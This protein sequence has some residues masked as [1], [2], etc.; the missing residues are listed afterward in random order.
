[1]E[2]LTRH[3]HAID[4]G[5][6]DLVPG[7]EPLLEQ[8]LERGL[9]RVQRD[10]TCFTQHRV[11]RLGVTII[12]GPQVHHHRGLELTEQRRTDRP[13]T[14]RPMVSATRPT[15]NR[16]FRDARVYDSQGQAPRAMSNRSSQTRGALLGLAAAALFGL[17]APLAKLLLG[18]ISPVL[19]GGLLYLGAACGLW[20]H[21]LVRPSTAETP[22]SGRDVPK[23]AAIV[24]TGGLLG[25][26]IML[27]GLQ[28]VTALAGSLLLNLEAPLT[29]LIAVVAFREHLGL[30]T[31]GAA[32]LILAGAAALEFQ[33]GDVGGEIVGAALIALACL[34]WAVDNNLTQRLT[35]RDPFAIVRVKTL[36]AGV[37]NTVLGLWIAGAELPEPGPVAAALTLGSLSYGVSILLDAY[38]LRL[39]GAVREAAYFAT[40]PFVGATGSLLLHD[41]QLGGLGLLA[42]IA[43]A[44]GVGLLLRERHSHWHAHDPLEHDHLHEHDEHH[45]HEHGADVPPGTRHSHAHRHVPIAHAHPHLPD[46]HHRHT[47]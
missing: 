10:G 38:A 17:T 43:M 30:R 31:A 20:L 13:R 5:V 35:L 41:E 33:P 21:R 14:H 19:L 18:A 29:I 23:L 9:D 22:L 11:D 46:V 26:V 12:A 44:A 47:H 27:F 24:I 37:G 7:Q 25:P 15:V 1:M 34:C 45:Q 8:A 2:L 39:V 3:R 16:Y 6:A 28:R 32:A 4:V 40:A 36:G 42:M